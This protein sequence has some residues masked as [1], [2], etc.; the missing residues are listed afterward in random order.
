M[1]AQ[2]LTQDYLKFIFDYKDGHLYWKNPK[3]NRV[4]IGDKAGNK[5]INGYF[6]T[7]IN[8]K[9]YK[10]HRLIF[11]MH[12]GY[13]PKMIDHI[14]GNPLNNCIENLREA[15]SFENSYN[16]K[17]KITNKLNVKNVYWN[18]EFKKYAVAITFNKKEN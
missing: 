15:T 3:S 17:T 6:S 10:N 7:K 14:D 4:K 11:L 1:T 18:K 12:H 5:N 9:L 16:R 13:L 8:S 2:I